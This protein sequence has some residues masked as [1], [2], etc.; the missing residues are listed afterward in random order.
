ME[1]TSYTYKTVESKTVESGF[2][3]F[4]KY[5]GVALK[6][7]LTKRNINLSDV[8]KIR[9]E[10]QNQLAGDVLKSEAKKYYITLKNGAKNVLNIS[11]SFKV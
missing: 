8:A 6:R 2:A 5:Q 7:R 10:H 4:V 9:F 11:K 3:T 1:K